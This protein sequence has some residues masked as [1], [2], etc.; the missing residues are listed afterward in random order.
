MLLIAGLITLRCPH[1][2]VLQSQTE[3][4]VRVAQSGLAVPA[5]GGPLEGG[6]RRQRAAGYLHSLVG[7]P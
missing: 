2:Q 1:M 5:V 4:I 7:L 3:P 6:V